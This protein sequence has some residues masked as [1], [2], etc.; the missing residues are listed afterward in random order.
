MD[1][2]EIMAGPAGDHRRDELAHVSPN[3]RIAAERDGGKILTKSRP[4]SGAFH[5]PDARVWN[6]GTGFPAR[7]AVPLP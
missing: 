6:A 5:A 4:L 1:K 3:H 2:S 7:P